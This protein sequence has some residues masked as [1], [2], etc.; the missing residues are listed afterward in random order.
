MVPLRRLLA[1]SRVSKSRF[2]SRFR[3]TVYLPRRVAI[4][5]EDLPQDTL[6]SHEM[7][8]REMF[9]LRAGICLRDHRREVRIDHS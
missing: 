3:K 2:F 5:F 4:S 7:D 1:L 9:D 6:H 8:S